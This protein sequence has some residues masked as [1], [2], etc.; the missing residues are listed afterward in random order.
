MR[1]N[2]NDL[3]ISAIKAHGIAMYPPGATFGPRRLGDYEFVWMIEG[4]AV[5]H[6]NGLDLPAPM[7]SILLCTP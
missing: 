6:C 2:V 4:D 5:Y 3:Q 7:G 1:E